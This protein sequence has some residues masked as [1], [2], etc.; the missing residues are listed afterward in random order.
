MTPSEPILYSITLMSIVG[1]PIALG[2]GLVKKNWQP[3]MIRLAPWSA[4]PAL[5]AV[6]W[7]P[8]D[9][10]CAVPWLLLETR[11]AVDPTGRVFLMFTSL[12]WFLSGHYA[13]SYLA[14]D[15]HRGRFF[16]FFQLSMAGNLGLIISQDVISFYVF[17]R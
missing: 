7:I 8:A 2:I 12:L 15:P 1:L 17:L 3:W 14:S 13:G 11:L 10:I 9:H 6:I 16:L 4:L 5:A